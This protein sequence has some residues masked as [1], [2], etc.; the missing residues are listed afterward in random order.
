MSKRAASQTRD[1][2][3]PLKQGERPEGSDE[4]EMGPFED[5][6]EDV[7][8]DEIVEIDGE[9]KMVRGEGDSEDEDG[10]K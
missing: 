3:V 5:D 1:G 9:G 8:E 2:G 6:Q 7:F 10:G 4:D